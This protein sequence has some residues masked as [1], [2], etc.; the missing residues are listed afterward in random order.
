MQCGADQE[1]GIVVVGED[2]REIH[3]RGAAIAALVLRTSIP[4]RAFRSLK[5]ASGA[6]AIDSASF[7]LSNAVDS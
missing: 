4:T 3:V 5:L 7:L 2:T 6:L 1:V